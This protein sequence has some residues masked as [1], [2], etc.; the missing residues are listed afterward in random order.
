[1]NAISQKWCT[2]KNLPKLCFLHNTDFKDPRFT[3]C[4]RSAKF[5]EHRSH[6]TELAQLCV[7]QKLCNLFIL[8]PLP[9]CPHPLVY[10]AAIGPSRG[11]PELSYRGIIS[12]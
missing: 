1:M 2:H 7:E 8:T 6:P 5:G 10:M 9:Y 4:A 3:E 12:F 11:Q